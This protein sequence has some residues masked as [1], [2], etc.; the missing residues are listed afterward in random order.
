MARALR[1]RRL[2]LYGLL[3]LVTVALAG[4]ASSQTTA[5]SDFRISAGTSLR[6][7]GQGPSVFGDTIGLDFRSG[8]LRA[9]WADN[10][11]SAG[12]DLATAAIAVTSNGSASVGPTVIIRAADDLTNA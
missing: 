3:A 4:S 5:G 7:D 12:F 1:Q 8:I 9:A 11:S 10:S 6:F 2:P